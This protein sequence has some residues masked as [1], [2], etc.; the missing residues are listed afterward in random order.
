MKTKQK[1]GKLKLV[2]GFGA[3]E[4]RHGLSLMSEEKE[5]V[6][7]IDGDLVAVNIT[8]TYSKRVCF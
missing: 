1:T 5:R 7:R 6:S 3:A 8:P 4:Q 2:R